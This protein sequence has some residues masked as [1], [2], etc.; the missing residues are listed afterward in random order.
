MSIFKVYKLLPPSI[1]A[2]CSDTPSWKWQSVISGPLAI[3]HVAAFKSYVYSDLHSMIHCPWMRYLDVLYK[4][5]QSRKVALHYKVI[6]DL[7]AL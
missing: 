2:A 5:V 1:I 7:L 4:A 6:Q 3:R